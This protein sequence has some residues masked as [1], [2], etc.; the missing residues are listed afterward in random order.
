MID[1]KSYKEHGYLL[2]KGLFQRAEIDVI[3]NEAKQVFIAQ[4]HRLNLLQTDDVSEAMFER[5]MA[6][7]FD[8]DLQTFTNCGKQ[9][10]HLISL[11]RLSLDERVVRAIVALGLEFP[12]VSTRPVLSFN[13]RRLAKKEV[14][15]R[16][17]SHQDWRSMQ[18]SLDAIVVW[19][20]LVD[21]NQSLGALGDRPGQP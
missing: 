19:V 5:G 12:N 11:H 15:W 18:G 6:E 7:L 13:S 9:V 17:S 20:P 2:V 21:I 10:Q 4:M 16:L 3:R 1:V 8:A 14:Y